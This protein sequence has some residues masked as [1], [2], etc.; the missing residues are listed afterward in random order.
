MKIAAVTSAT[1]AVDHSTAASPTFGD[2]VA[3]EHSPLF[4]TPT[5]VGAISTQRAKLTSA[6]EFLLF[7][8]SPLTVSDIHIE[9]F[10]DA[11]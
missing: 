5:F 10:S 11:M 8:P 9:N 4:T 3:T 2:S 6:V 1:R 7:T